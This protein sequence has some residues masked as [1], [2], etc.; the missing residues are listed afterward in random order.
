MSFGNPTGLRNGMMG[1]LR[2]RNFEVKGRV[3]MG[4]DVDG[5]RYYWNEYNIVDDSGERATL[6]YEETGRGGEWKL[7][8]MFEPEFP[9]T[10]ADAATRKIGDELNLEGTQVRVTLVDESRVYHIDGQ[11][12]EGVELEDIAHYFN[13][14]ARNVMIVVSWTGNEVEYFRGETLARGEVARA[15]NIPAETRNNF[16]QTQRLA[17][18]SPTGWK[19]AS[20]LLPL[21]VF[22]VIAFLFATKFSSCRSQRNLPPM[23]HTPASAAKLQVG[24]RGYLDG[25]RQ[26]VR[27]HDLVEIATVGSLYD[28]HEYDLV[29]DEESSSLLVQNPK[30]FALYTPMQPFKPMTPAAAAALRVGQFVDVDGF[31][32]PV[33]EL[34]QSAIRVTNVVSLTDVRTAEVSYGFTAKTN[35]ILLLV[36]WSSDHIN[37]YRGRTISEKE[38]TT[39]FARP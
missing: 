21:F 8:T 33:S 35:T 37:F 28:R 7:F 20:T 26:R 14:E 34:F 24:S 38:V 9:M 36:R 5:S 15:F 11:S 30:D 23:P 32:A 29:D 31:I 19:F 22:G 2:D 25:K 13:A 17:D 6:V 18:G 16:F 4:A 3:V 39:A 1:R 10:A 12:P 27:V